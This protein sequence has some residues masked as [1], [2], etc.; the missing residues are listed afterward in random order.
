MLLQPLR[1]KWCILEAHVFPIV[2]SSPARPWDVRLHHFRD[3]RGHVSWYNPL[4]LVTGVAPL[5]G[6]ESQERSDFLG[7]KII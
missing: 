7:C 1:H 2:Q 3:G 4:A 6:E 5:F